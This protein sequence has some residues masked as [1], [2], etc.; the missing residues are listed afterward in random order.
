MVHDRQDIP[1]C[2]LREL[3]WLW[4]HCRHEGGVKPSTRGAAM[5]SYQPAGPSVRLQHFDGHN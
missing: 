1:K 3:V 5:A 2:L 4:K